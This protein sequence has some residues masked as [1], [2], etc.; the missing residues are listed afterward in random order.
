MNKHDIHNYNQFW[1][2]M[3]IHS[4]RELY[5]LWNFDS[6]NRYCYNDMNTNYTFVH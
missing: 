5:N 2:S 1:E 4:Y 3:I 6:N